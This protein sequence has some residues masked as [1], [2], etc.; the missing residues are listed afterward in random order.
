MLAKYQEYENVV[1]EMGKVLKKLCELLF[2]SSVES[3]I[4]AVITMKEQLLAAD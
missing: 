2:V 3:L 1:P 4:P